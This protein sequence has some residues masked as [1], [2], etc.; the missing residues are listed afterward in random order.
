M[1]AAAVKSTVDGLQT[2]AGSVITTLGIPMVST[3]TFEVAGHSVGTIA[4]ASIKFPKELDP[5]AELTQV[6]RRV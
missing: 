3:P 5:P 6:N 4:I 2:A 1:T